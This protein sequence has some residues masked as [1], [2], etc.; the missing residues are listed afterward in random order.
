MEIRKGSK[1]RIS[2]PREEYR[3]WTER[4]ESLRY[5]CMLPVQVLKYNLCSVH[6]NKIDTNL[7]GEAN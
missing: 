6:V 3:V 5:V 7:N 4:K 1:E 2:I